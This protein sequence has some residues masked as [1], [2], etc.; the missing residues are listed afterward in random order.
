MAQPS[1]FTG[2]KSHFLTEA[3]F[4]MME[5]AF[6]A[7]HNLM[8]S[9]NCPTMQQAVENIW[10]RNEKYAL[11]GGNHTHASQTSL[12]EYSCC[13]KL[14]E[15]FVKNVWGDD[16]DITKEPFPPVKIAMF[17]RNWHMFL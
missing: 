9:H 1:T 13:F 10:R 14:L 15:V 11:R 8:E 4:Q 2:V 3:S 7:E 16:I 17:Y 5:E 6:R 12:N